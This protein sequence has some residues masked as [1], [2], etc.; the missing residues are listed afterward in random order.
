[1]ANSSVASGSGNRTQKHLKVD[2]GK[3][4]DLYHPYLRC[5]PRYCALS[6][7]D[8]RLVDESN[9]SH[10]TSCLTAYASM[11]ELCGGLDGCKL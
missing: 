11:G 9:R 8:K 7:D 10:R 1:M 6:L 2:Y 4:Y 5:D 3:D